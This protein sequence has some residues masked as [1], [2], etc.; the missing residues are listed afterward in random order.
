ILSQAVL[1]NVHRF[2]KF[3]EEDFSRMNQGEFVFC[4][5]SVLMVINDLRVIDVALAPFKTNAPLVVNANTVLT[6]TVT[7]QFLE[8]IGWWYAQVL[9]RLCAIQDLQLSPR[10][11]LNVLRQLARELALKQLCGFFVLK[12]LDHEGMVTQAVMIV[13]RY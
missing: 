6:F 9:Q 8:V 4:H 7:E 10:Y 3:F 2:Q 11:T 5:G 13:D 12:A 1:S